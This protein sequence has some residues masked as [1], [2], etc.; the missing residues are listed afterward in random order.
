[1][2][3]QS[4]PDT[5][6]ID[7]RLLVPVLI[8]AVL[9]QTI[10]SIVRVTTSYRA[11]E[12]ELSVVWLGVIS[13]AFAL[14]PIAIAVSVGRYIDRGH[15]AHAAWIGSALFAV[16]CGGFAFFPS[17]VA[18]LAC[19]ALLGVG[20]LFLMASQQM[21]CVR[22]GGPRGL[23]RVFGNYMVAGAIGQGLGPYIVGWAGGAATL[24]PTRLLFM[25]AFITA[26]VTVLITFAV[27]PRQ[28]AAHHAESSALVPITSL[29][30][31][32]GL[33]AV[34]L[35]GVFI[36]TAQDLVVIYLPILGAER[37]IDVNVIGFLLTVRAICSMISR[38]F[39][40]RVVMAFGRYPLMVGCTLA[41]G[42]A[43][44]ALAAPLPLWAMYLA[45]A[46]MGLALGIATT[47]SVTTVVDRTPAAARGT[48]NSLRIMGNRLGQVSLPFGAG[49]VAAAAGV[50]G[51]LVMIALSL[52]ASAAGVHLTR[53]K[54]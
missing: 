2:L 36:V 28:P 50:A 44:A 49:L 11:I 25:A 19:T 27:R 22:A 34:I 30:R 38:V 31:V 29:L 17:A 9:I 6:D 45:M 20:H 1:M 4:S 40:A 54:S 52:A 18:L 3:Q 5:G 48:A 26:A 7:Y 16:A 24:P 47:L 39:Y 35:A 21:L 41:G 8:N 13:A 12:L 15:D 33:N 46:V 51:I 37:A 42:L 43:F 23:D 53:P 32:P 10:V 14:F